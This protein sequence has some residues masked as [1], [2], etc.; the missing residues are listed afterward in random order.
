M[1]R[2]MKKGPEIRRKMAFYLFED[3]SGMGVI[4]V[5]LIILVLVGLALIFRNQIT[6]IAT[7]LFNT[8]RTEISQF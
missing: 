4:E 5:I 1:G 2:Q 3:R 6:A 7:S 8:L